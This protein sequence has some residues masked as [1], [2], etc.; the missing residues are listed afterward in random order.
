MAAPDEIMGKVVAVYDVACH[1]GQQKHTGSQLAWL[2]SS[3]ELR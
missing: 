2:R 3:R 1:A